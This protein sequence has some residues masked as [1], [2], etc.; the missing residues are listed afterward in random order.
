MFLFS[1]VLLYVVL[2]VTPL[3]QTLPSSTVS[4]LLSE[5]APRPTDAPKDIRLRDA[6]QRAGRCG[7]INDSTP[8][9]CGG[10]STCFFNTDKK[11]AGCCSSSICSW[12]T[13]CAPFSTQPVSVTAGRLPISIPLQPYDSARMINPQQIGPS[14]NGFGKGP[15]LF[16]IE[17]T[18]Y[19][20]VLSW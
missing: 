15:G 20:E 7:Y 19:S 12:V 5:D 2:L 3:V 14:V 16:T 6:T 10:S 9:E 17:G 13:R 11:A 1:I 8:W 4:Q 18:V